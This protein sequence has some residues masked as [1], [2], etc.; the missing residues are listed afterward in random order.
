VVGGLFI[1]GT[2]I[3]PLL[4]MITTSLRDPGLVPPRQLEW[5]PT[6]LVWSNYGDVFE[7]LPFAI[8]ARNSL[9]VAGLA[10]P[11]SVLSASWA[12]F[13][14][15]QLRPRPRRWIVAFA[16]VASL[17]PTAGIWVSRFILFSELNLVD[18]W[19]PLI[20]PALTGT[21][22]LFTLVFLWSYSG[23]PRDIID[24]ARLDGSSAVRIWATI[25]F[26]LVRS[27]TVAVTMLTFTLHWN[28]FTDPLIYVHSMDRQTL[29]FALSALFQLAP[30]DWPLLM[31]AATM[32]TVPVIVVFL[33]GQR[34][35]MNGSRGVG[36]L[37]Q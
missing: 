10:V 12:G 19:W 3:L 29:P 24:A 26:P 23:I 37:S 33:L 22:P 34:A 32:L 25:C 20:L 28:N 9:I 21:S 36:W 17:V 16:L 31:A 1:S 2:V 15:A 35:F 5:L 8:M 14:I 4:W 27:T 11:L 18:S 13:A 7:M 30:T 6:P